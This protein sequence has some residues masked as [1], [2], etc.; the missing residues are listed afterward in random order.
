MKHT[1]VIL[2][3]ELFFEDVTAVDPPVSIKLG[4]LLSR[5]S[6]KRRFKNAVEMCLEQDVSMVYPLQ[7]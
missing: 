3:E 2:F 5:F 7:I 1:Q 4:P 6:W